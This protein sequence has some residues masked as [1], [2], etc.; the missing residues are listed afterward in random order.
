VASAYVH[1]IWARISSSEWFSTTNTNSFE[2]PVDAGGE[3]ARVAGLEVFAWRGDGAW[4][5]GSLLD[6]GA[7]AGPAAE[8]EPVSAPQAESATAAIAATTASRPMPLDATR[9][10][11]DGRGGGKL[12]F[13]DGRAWPPSPK[14][15]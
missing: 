6:E 3:E 8:D 13:A 1:G 4:E 7:L 10:A 12:V 11:D 9:L 5:D 2:T 14:G 15:R